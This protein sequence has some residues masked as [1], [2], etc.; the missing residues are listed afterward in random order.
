MDQC[1]RWSQEHYSCTLSS[2]PPCPSVFVI[3]QTDS[4]PQPVL[5]RGGWSFL[6]LV[7]CKSHFHSSAVPE[8][9]LPPGE[10]HQSRSHCESPELNCE[11]PAGFPFTLYFSDIFGGEDKC[12][13][14]SPAPDVGLWSTRPRRSTASTR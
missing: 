12:L 14:C 5:W 6:D 2:E 1:H 13:P 7:S 11:P 9:S 3:L 8:L 10:T 4:W